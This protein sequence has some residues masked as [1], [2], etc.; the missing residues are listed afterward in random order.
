MSLAQTGKT[1]GP[2]RRRGDRVEARRS[3]TRADPRRLGTVLLWLLLVSMFFG[4]TPFWAN[5]DPRLGSAIN[6]GFWLVVGAM[7]AISIF[8]TRP[9]AMALARKLWPVAVPLAWFGF[10]VFWSDFPRLTLERVAILWITVVATFA[11][12]ACKVPKTRLVQALLLIS[13][14]ALLANAGS[15]FVVPDIALFISEGKFRGMHGNPNTAGTATALTFLAFLL[16]VPASRALSQKVAMGLV[17]GLAFWFLLGTESATSIGAAIVT[18]VPLAVLLVGRRLSL[19]GQFLA[20]S[21]A[22][23]ALVAGM[24]WLVAAGVGAG[25]IADV[26]FGDTTFTGRTYLWAALMDEIRGQ[27]WVGSAYGAFWYLDSAENA[28]YATSG[29]LSGVG[30]AHNGFLD[31]VLQAGVIGFLVAMVPLTHMGMLA[32]RYSHRM[33]VSRSRKWL[34]LLPVGLFVFVVVHNLMESSLFRSGSTLAMA[35]FLSYFLVGS[36]EVFDKTGVKRDGRRKR[37]RAGASGRHRVESEASTRGG[38]GRPAV[39]QAR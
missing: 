4:L 33:R 28:L 30:Q 24:I 23:V 14:A 13:G 19:V 6:K 1:V 26:T 22:G 25:D 32:L 39:E 17:A 18:L 10:S 5:S 9:A 35:F 38:R 36:W 8:R 27:P 15:V 3:A 11:V 12:A 34:S 21:L 2:S 29:F 7:S 20:A 16:A 31:L 37:R